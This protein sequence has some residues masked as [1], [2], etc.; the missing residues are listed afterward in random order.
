MQARMGTLFRTSPHP[1]PDPAVTPPPFQSICIWNR[2]SQQR[3][4]REN[5]GQHISVA[6]STTLPLSHTLFSHLLISKHFLYIFLFCC[7]LASPTTGRNGTSLLV[8]LALVASVLWRKMIPHH[9][10]TLP[11]RQV[12][13]GPWLRYSGRFTECGNP[14]PTH[15]HSV[16]GLIKTVAVRYAKE[17]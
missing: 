8:F 4:N 14:R 17:S 6:V 5:N 11:Y 15:S 3:T 1:R 9:S 12:A 2:I 16:F 7:Y 10:K 13:A